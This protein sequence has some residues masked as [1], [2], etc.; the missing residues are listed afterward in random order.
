MTSLLAALGVIGPALLLVMA[1]RKWFEP[2]SWKLTALF[3]LLALAVVGRGIF[4]SGV[5]V[6]LDEVVRGYP[7]RGIFGDIQAQNYL[8][9]DTVKQI[10]PWMHTVREQMFAGRAPL[11]N[12]HLFSGYPLLG[13]GQSAPFSP[14]FLAT[15]YVPLPK[16]I[17]AMAG[18]KLFV[19][20]RFG[21][22][23]LRREGVSTAA[24]L[25]GCTVF[26]FAI[27]NNV[28]LYYP[29]TAVTLLLPAAAYAVLS[30]LHSRRAAP[31]VLVALVVA[32]L[33]AGGHPESVVHVATAVLV[34]VLIEWISGA[35]ATPPANVQ[36]EQEND[37][38]EVARDQ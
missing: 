14:F 19:A 23:L 12:P 4:T 9:N 6:P 34:L 36:N 24:A 31:H 20:L 29:M 10:L 2:V 1:V 30:A 8:T 18:V 11:W 33:L 17:V 22:L 27:F 16:Q 38:G 25:F 7:Y 15:L 35:R 13:N 3:L 21:F 28:F 32:L 5:P 26:T 37:A